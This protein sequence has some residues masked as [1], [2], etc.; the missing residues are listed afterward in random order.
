MAVGFLPSSRVVGT[1][2]CLVFGLSFAGSC[3]LS[4]RCGSVEEARAAA[5]VIVVT[6]VHACIMGELTQAGE[7]LR[8]LIG[9]VGGLSDVVFEVIE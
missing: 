1:S 7:D 8:M 4:H 6:E 3:C 9:D 5:G 2:F